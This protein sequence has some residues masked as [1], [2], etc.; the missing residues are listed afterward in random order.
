VGT[1]RGEELKSGQGDAEW[2]RFFTLAG[3]A[4]ARIEGTAIGKNVP[5]T[6]SAFDAE[7]ST[8]KAKLKVYGKMGAYTVVPNLRQGS[9]PDFRYFVLSFELRS[10]RV[11]I[12][13]FT[14][15]QIGEAMLTYRRVEA[16]HMNDSDFDT[17]LVSAGSLDELTEAYPNYF[18]ETVT[19]LGSIYS[20]DELGQL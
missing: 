16:L 5:V 10:R 3:S 9:N 11:S 14:P 6:P 13:G 8:L 15:D 17:V 2:L 12:W 18:G 4:L 19:F 20:P 7:F 1:F